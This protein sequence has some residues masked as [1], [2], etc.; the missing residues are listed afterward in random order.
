M[1]LLKTTH[2]F[3]ILVQLESNMCIYGATC[4]LSISD[5]ITLLAVRKYLLHSGPCPG[6]ENAGTDPHG[7]RGGGGDGGGA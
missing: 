5:G 3:E 6:E 7:G 4:P 1:T 2:F